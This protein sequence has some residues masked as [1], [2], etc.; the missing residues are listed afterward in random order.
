MRQGAIQPLGR[1]IKQRL[2]TGESAAAREITAY[3]QSAK[4]PFLV[5]QPLA[6][7]DDM[8]AEES[9][10][11][12]H[13]PSDAVETVGLN[14]GTNVT[15]VLELPGRFARAEKGAQGQP[16]PNGGLRAQAVG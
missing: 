14:G 15:V 8:M 2:R 7:L 5:G 16:G 4:N 12:K 1:L 3:A 9:L 11:G 6:F 13:R 10:V